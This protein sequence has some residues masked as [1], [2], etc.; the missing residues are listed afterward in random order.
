[1]PLWSN[2]SHPATRRHQII[3]YKPEIPSED[4][5]LLESAGNRRDEKHGSYMQSK[6]RAKKA[7]L[8]WQ[9]PLYTLYTWDQQKT[10][11][12]K[13]R[14]GGFR[15]Q[16]DLSGRSQGLQPLTGLSKGPMTLKMG[17][18]LKLE[19]WRHTVADKQSRLIFSMNPLGQMTL[20]LLVYH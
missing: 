8:C 12:K 16:L 11:T 10:K 6:W 18:D 17:W 14:S 4:S 19:A 15:W 13:E 1:M 7:S 2:M 20:Y 5:N 9:A 3:Q